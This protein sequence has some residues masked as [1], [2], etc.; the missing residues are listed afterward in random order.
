MG[1][2]IAQVSVDNGK[3]NVL[4]K[5]K[6]VAGVS[7]GEKTID[8]A[9][10]GKLKKKKITNHTYCETTSRLTALHD[11]IDSWKKHFG[12]ADIVIEAVFEELSVKH[13][14]LKEMEEVLHRRPECFRWLR[15]D[16]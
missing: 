14:V 5:D 4:L 6:D 9:L 11:N 15:T 8:D 16:Y 3:Y 13:K 12:K 2:G 10:K 7:R 1:A